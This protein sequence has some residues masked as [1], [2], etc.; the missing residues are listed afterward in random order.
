MILAA[1]RGRRMRPLTDATPKPL[2]SVGGWPLIDWHL[3]AVARAGVDEVVINT[4][5]L[6]ERIVGHVGDG[7]AWGVSVQYSHEGAEG[8]ET[9]GGIRQ[10]LP[11]LGDEPFWV[12]N[13]DVWTDF[14][15]SD[16]PVRPAGLAHLVL[17]ANPAHNP[18]GDFRLRHDG[19]VV[20]EADAE[21]LTFA[22]IGCY[23]PL[24]FRDTEA[25]SFRLAPLLRGA[26]ERG[27]VTAAKHRG[28][29][30]DIGTPQRLDSVD[31]YLRRRG[32]TP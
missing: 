22:G 13:G 31:G 4:A 24:L 20:S 18:A 2:L 23:D 29:W 26:A 5:W 1:G 30:F 15:P 27:Q 16:L 19:L 6:S 10:A 7:S 12:I 9:G 28:D 8:L 3:R 21:P 14:D 25:G 32:A 11:L 17:V